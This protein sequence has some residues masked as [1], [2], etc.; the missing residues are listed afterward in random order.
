LGDRIAVSVNV[1]GVQLDSDAIIEEVADALVRSGLDATSLILEVTE[2]ALMRTPVATAR[3]R[4]RIKR[5]G[6]RI[7]VDDFGTGYSSLSYLQQLPVDSLKIDRMFTNAIA[8][9]PE[10]KALIGPLVQL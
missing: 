5:R 4:P 10:S 6:V 3:P 9:S 8:P 1:S 2:T 7:A